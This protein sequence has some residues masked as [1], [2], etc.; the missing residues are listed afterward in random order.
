MNGLLIDSRK[1]FAMNTTKT[2]PHDTRQKTGNATA[3]DAIFQSVQ[4]HI[5]AET[6]RDDSMQTG[7]KAL[8]EASFARHFGGFAGKTYY[9]VMD[10]TSISQENWLHEDFP[11]NGFFTDNVDVSLLSWK[12][13]RRN[14]SQLAPDIQAKINT[15]LGNQAI[16]VP[17][18]LDEKMKRNP[19]LREK[20][21]KTIDQMYAYHLGSGPRLALPGTKFYGTRVFSAVMILNEDGEVAHCRVSSGG[22]M[23]GPDEETLRKIEREQKSKAERK[24][25]SRRLNAKAA[26]K[27]F[28]DY[29]SLLHLET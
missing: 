24:A 18:A 23:I 2:A 11:Y 3:F 13:T 29:Y 14:P 12:P 6:A 10:A 28:E 25:E 20:V 9:H 26:M 5:G 17:P 1:C 8:C 15:T 7:L 21:S 16:I 27:H 19:A 22:G 4:S